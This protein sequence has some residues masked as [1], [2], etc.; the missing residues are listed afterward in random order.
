MVKRLLAAL[1]ALSVWLLC[2]AVGIRS[3]R[4]VDTSA[5]S[6]A[7]TIELGESAQYSVQKMEG[8]RGI[9]VT[10]RDVSSLGGTPQ[11]P[12]LSE[13]IDRVSTRME[14]ANA[15]IDIKTMGDYDFSTR[16][17]SDNSRITVLINSEAAASA[18]QP[19]A[20]TSSGTK[21]R[22]P[23]QPPL[24][25][26]P[27][28]RSAAPE[29][30]QKTQESPT[31]VYVE[32]PSSPGETGSQADMADPEPRAGAAAAEEMNP[33]QNNRLLPLWLILGS[34]ALLCLWVILKY[35]VR[36]KP[37]A[38]PEATDPRKATATPAGTTLLLD[39]ETRLRMVQKLLDQGWTA[40]EIA[41][42]IRLDLQETEEIVR[43]LRNGRP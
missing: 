23:D 22:K 28:E 38:K 43:Q 3:V 33:R 18:T 34:T 20:T 39:P 13:V 25:A 42:E 8:G 6:N 2:P 10:I 29:D 32:D 5:T 21:L 35:L 30:P 9:R 16:A 14:G 19:Q 15:S 31:S 7:V 1:L 11:Y 12:R 17:N 26:P 37:R 41:R 36:R 27:L 40:T 24:P 4:S